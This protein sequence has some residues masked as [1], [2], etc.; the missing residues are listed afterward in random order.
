MTAP[1][2]IAESPCQPWT[3]PEALP[4]QDLVTPV[5][6][7]DAVALA[8]GA[9]SFVLWALSGR[10]YGQ[11]SVKVRPCRRDFFPF[12][13]SWH[14]WGSGYEPVFYGGEWFNV[15]GHQHSCSCD[16][17]DTV[18]LP[19]YGMV[20]ADAV[21]EV[22]VNGDVLDPSAYRVDNGSEL[23]RLD[24][25]RWPAC[26]NMSD[27][28]TEVG[29]WSITFTYGIGLD[30]LAMLAAGDF[31]CEFLKNRLGQSCK[32]PSRVQNVTRQGVSFTLLDPHTFLSEGRTGL[33]TVD[34][35]LSTVNPSALR[36]EPVVWSPDVNRR[37]P[38]RAGVN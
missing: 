21:T 24:G 1:T 27:P 4:C 29:T 28:D 17:V 25:Q 10:R 2:P 7:A 11:C 19:P 12:R 18:L 31:A 36:Q 26:Q 35:W 15:C 13:G 37:R 9:S 16:F 3:T 22:R 6:N 5:E 8:I 20:S 32:L 14:E 23:V 38:R 34:L 33:Y 30:S